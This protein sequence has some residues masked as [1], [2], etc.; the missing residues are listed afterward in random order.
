M[1]SG[2]G[3]IDAWWWPYVLILLIGWL[4]TDIWRMI[5]V[6]LA[7]GI[8][9]NSEQLVFVRAVATSLVAAVIAKLILFPAGSL[10]I[11]PMELRI[12]AAVAGFA[13]FLLTGKRVFVGILVGETSLI[14]GAW[15]L[16][17]F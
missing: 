2:F 9:E 11:A 13:S 10:A 15:L 7:G 5:G 8:D 3:F 6:A 1:E 16:G 17:V 4:P 14:G 12:I